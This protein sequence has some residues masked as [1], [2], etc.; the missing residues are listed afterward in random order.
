MHPRAPDYGDGLPGEGAITLPLVATFAGE[1]LWI[2]ARSED[3]FLG[4]HR[5]G[6]L[7]LNEDFYDAQFEEV[8]FA[9]DPAQLIV[10]YCGAAEC[11]SS[12]AIA[13]RLKRDLAT[14]NVVYLEEG[15][16]GLQAWP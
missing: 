6:A 1:I 7:N 4:G 15:W 14:E 11:A 9:W 2:D 16:E 13:L 12:Q 3:E 10:V 8:A 5:P